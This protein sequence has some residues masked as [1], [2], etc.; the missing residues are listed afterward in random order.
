MKLKF[1]YTPI[2]DEAKIYISDALPYVTDVYCDFRNLYCKVNNGHYAHPYTDIQRPLDGGGLGEFVGSK[3]LQ[4]IEEFLK[5][6]LNYPIKATWEFFSLKSDKP[7]SKIVL[8]LKEINGNPSL[9]IKEYF[10]GSN[11]TGNGK[12]ETIELNQFED[13]YRMNSKGI[14]STYNQNLMNDLKVACDYFNFSFSIFN[15][16][17]PMSV[18]PLIKTW[19]YYYQL[20][21]NEK[22]TLLSY[23]IWKEE[24]MN[25]INEYYINLPMNEDSFMMETQNKTGQYYYEEIVSELIK[26]VNREN[27]LLERNESTPVGFSVG[28]IETVS[29][30]KKI[31]EAPIKVK[32]EEGEIFIFPEKKTTNLYTFSIDSIPLDNDIQLYKQIGKRLSFGDTKK[33]DYQ[34]LKNNY[35]CVPVNHPQFDFIYIFPHAVYLV[36]G[37][38]GM[39]LSQLPNSIISKKYDIKEVFL[40]KTKVLLECYTIQTNKETLFLI[41]LE[42][43]TIEC[44]K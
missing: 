37:H 5:T 8:S 31:N 21:V 1:G 36:R 23:F 11:S 28:E 2:Q 20:F 41:D 35:V 42:T 3:G 14:L 13:Y 30:Q 34:N 38:E 27:L 10:V 19:S 33:F 17:Q 15:I 18:C 6:K 22:H 26:Y 29:H 25:S 7:H 32:E 16:D 4:Q 40:S 9:E 44:R 12:K 43:V 39:E 24:N